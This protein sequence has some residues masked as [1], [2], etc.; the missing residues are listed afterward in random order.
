MANFILKIPILIREA[1]ANGI[2]ANK[3]FIHSFEI[4]PGPANQPMTRTTQ[5]WNKAGLKK[6]Q[7]KE[8]PGVTLRADPASN[9][10]TFILFF[11]FLLKRRRLKKN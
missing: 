7:K 5:G 1:K 2:V 6:K 8:K 10:L 9:P 11:F 4:R 3:H